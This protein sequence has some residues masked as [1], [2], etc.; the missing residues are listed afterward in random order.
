MDIRDLIL[1]DHPDRNGCL[2]YA[3]ITNIAWNTTLAGETKTYTARMFPGTDRERDFTVEEDKCCRLS[4]WNSSERDFWQGS[5]SYKSAYDLANERGKF[6]P[7]AA[8]TPEAVA[9]H[10]ALAQEDAAAAP[11]APPADDSSPL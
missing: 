8:P 11:A 2:V 9:A 3:V 4:H 1:T 10:A 5:D 7:P 6:A